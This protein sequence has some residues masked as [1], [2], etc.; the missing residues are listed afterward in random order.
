MANDPARRSRKR[1]VLDGAHLLI[2]HHEPPFMNRCWHLTVRGHTLHVCARCSALLVGV[3]LAMTVQ[4]RFLYIPV[5][6]ITF[7]GAFLLSLPAVVDWSTQTL[8]LRESRNRVRALTGG[9]LGFAVGYVLTSGNLLYYLIVVLLYS[10]YTLG[11][12]AVASR[13]VARRRKRESRSPPMSSSARSDISPT[14][15]QCQM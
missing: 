8:S 1:R 7:F 6:P 14:W 12:A 4:F 2:S 15:L 3:L 10:G 9:L 5:T 11:F 13:I